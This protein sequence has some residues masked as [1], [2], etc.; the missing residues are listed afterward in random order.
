MYNVLTDFRKEIPAL[1]RGGDDSVLGLN[2]Q[3]REDF[4]SR[5]QLEQKRGS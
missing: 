3:V 2:K 5:E 4:R 1:M